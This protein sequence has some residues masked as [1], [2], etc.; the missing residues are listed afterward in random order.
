MQTTLSKRTKTVASC[1]PACLLSLLGRYAN[2]TYVL[3]NRSGGGLNSIQKQVLN[4]MDSADPS[5]QQ[6]AAD[7]IEGEMSAQGIRKTILAFEKAMNKNREM[8][9][10]FSN[11]PEKYVYTPRHSCH[12]A[13]T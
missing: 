7:G 11:D 3:S 10:R 5:E 1:K 12:T 6:L 9:T 13:T 2:L 8:R 4:I